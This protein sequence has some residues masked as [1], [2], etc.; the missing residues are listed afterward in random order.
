M[1][2]MSL[3][4]DECTTLR[5]NIVKNIYTLQIMTEI[6]CRNR[7]CSQCPLNF[8]H[9][10]GCFLSKMLA[11]LDNAPVLDNALIELRRESKHVEER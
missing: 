1:S 10:D 5:D 9:S 11:A 4:T 7:V 8:P 6:M 3:T 2:I